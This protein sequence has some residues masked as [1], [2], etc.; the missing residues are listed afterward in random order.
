MGVMAG[1]FDAATPR[2]AMGVSSRLSSNV[3][4]ALRKPD[5]TPKPVGRIQIGYDVILIEIVH[6]VYDL[7]ADRP[8]GRE[9]LRE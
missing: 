5:A 8:F 1:G 4:V 7:D 2:E 6:V 9:G 3:L